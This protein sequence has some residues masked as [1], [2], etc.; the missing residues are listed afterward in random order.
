MVRGLG[1]QESKRWKLQMSINKQLMIR[2]GAENM[3]RYSRTNLYC[4]YSMV[5]FSVLKDSDKKE[6]VLLELSYVNNN[7]Q[8]LRE[9]MVELDSSEEISLEPGEGILL[10]M[11]PVRLKE[12]KN[13]N[14]VIVVKQ[15]IESHYFE[16]SSNYEDPLSQ[17]RDLREAMRTPTKDSCGIDLLFQ[18]YNQLH[19]L[20][21]RFFK[22]E[23]CRGIHFTW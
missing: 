10:P 14:F 20:E 1:K 19:F 11:I 21:R 3:Y 5:Y 4:S 23:M 2:K 9:E 7:L 12:T 8:V 17:L 18:Y 13:L 6:N 16:D 22:S 15:F